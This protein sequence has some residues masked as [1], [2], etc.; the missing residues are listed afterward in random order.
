MSDLRL[1]FGRVTQRDWLILIALVASLGM[2]W[3]T[4]S[5]YS[6][7]TTIP[8]YF[9]PD[10]YV[11]VT[12]ADGYMYTE[13]IPG[14]VGAPI[15]L[16]GL[17][18]YTPATDHPARFGVAAAILFIFASAWYRRRSLQVIGGVLLIIT[19]ALT[20]GLGFSAPG[21]SVGWLVGFALIAFE[22][23]AIRARLPKF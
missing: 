19:T 1:I 8:G 22:T 23:P 14:F 21:S 6:P 7:G 5:Y 2:N 15:F 16:P 11:N 13:T 3:A 18:N 10:S 12:G 17:M 4:A 9:V 20:S